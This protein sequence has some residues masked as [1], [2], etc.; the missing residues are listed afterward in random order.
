VESQTTVPEEVWDQD[1]SQSGAVSG[2]IPDYAAPV[3]VEGVAAVREVPTL[4]ATFGLL[5]IRSG[6]SLRI[7]RNGRRRRLTLS[8]R[9]AVPTS[10]FVQLSATGTAVAGPV[11]LQ[12]I[13]FSSTDGAVSGAG[14]LEIRD[15][16]GTTVLMTLRVLQDTS[17]TWES[18]T[19]DGVKF[20]TGIHA[21]IS[22]A[23]PG[24][25]ATFQYTTGAAA[26]VVVAETAMQATGGY[27]LPITAGAAPVTLNYAGELHVAAAG[28]DAV[29]GF[30]AELDQG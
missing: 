21:T 3:I 28:A 14:K 16:A 7:G 15:G 9:P 29:V 1:V 25:F 4:G 19:L 13:T 23:G 22:G 30:V 20:T 5:T 17:V 27:G 24:V 6:T 18:G 12:S 11:Y 26:Y 8:V 2:D 10:S